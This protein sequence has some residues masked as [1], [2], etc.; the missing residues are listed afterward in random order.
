MPAV[1]TVDEPT[2][3]H[4]AALAGAG[5]AYL[6]RWSVAE[7]LAEGRLESVLEDW[8]PEELGLCLYY[9]RGRHPSAGLRALIALV[10]ARGRRRGER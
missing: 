7:D 1:L 8:L 6:A 4:Q 5:Y 3:A 10:R 9:P 2:L